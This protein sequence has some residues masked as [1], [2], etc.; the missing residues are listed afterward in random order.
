[1]FTNINTLK[2]VM[3]KMTSITNTMG[4]KISRAYNIKDNTD[5]DMG[6][7]TLITLLTL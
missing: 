1:M 5:I 2:T 3:I 7:I 4:I 6:I